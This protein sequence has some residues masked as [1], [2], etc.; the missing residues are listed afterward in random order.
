MRRIRKFTFAL[1][2][3]AALTAF[4]RAGET[5]TP[6]MVAPA[7]AV[8]SDGETPTPGSSELLT[9]LLIDI[10]GFLLPIF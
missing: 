3:V 6:G 7:P 9:E 8:S 4:A 1:L 10:V 5:P 2:L